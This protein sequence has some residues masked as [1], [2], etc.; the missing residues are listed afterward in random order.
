MNRFESLSFVLF[1]AHTA[2]CCANVA[3]QEVAIF[4]YKKEKGRRVKA[5]QVDFARF[6]KTRGAIEPTLPCR[7]HE[8][9]RFPCAKL[10]RF[11]CE[12]RQTKVTTFVMPFFWLRFSI[13][14]TQRKS[15]ITN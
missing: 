8:L 15:L 14:K 9:A 3:A 5:R 4:V 10:S 1:A 13:D 6:V 12:G 11:F 2:R 7:A